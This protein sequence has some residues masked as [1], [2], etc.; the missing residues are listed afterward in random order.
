MKAVLKVRG[1]SNISDVNKIR[2]AI[3]ENEGVVACEISR[4]KEEISIVYD[5]HSVSLDSIAISIEDL[6]YTV[7]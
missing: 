6:G 4:Q 5:N 1:I 2:R 7:I 3:A